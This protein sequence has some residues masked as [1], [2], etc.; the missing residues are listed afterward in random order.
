[1]SNTSKIR[2]GTLLV[3]SQTG[4]LQALASTKLS[5]GTGQERSRFAYRIATIRSAV[6]RQIDERSDYHAE[7]T[8]HEGDHLID[9]ERDGQPGREL[10]APMG[11]HRKALEEAIA[12]LLE[13]EVS[14]DM[15]QVTIDELGAF[16]V[17]LT[18]EQMDMLRFCIAPPVEEAEPAAA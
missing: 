3:A 12:G 15:P 11:E 16:G 6:L 13:V 9:V 8:R 10:K 7:V 17:D 5:G 18:G 14:V 1:M 4:A 2:I